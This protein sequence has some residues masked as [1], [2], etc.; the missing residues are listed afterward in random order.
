MRIDC[1]RSRSI[2]VCEQG[3]LGSIWIYSKLLA[4]SRLL[5]F[6]PNRP[7][8]KASQSRESAQPRSTL[9]NF[10]IGFARDQPGSLPLAR[11]LT[12][13]HASDLRRMPPPRKHNNRVKRSSTSSELTYLTPIS[14]NTSSQRPSYL[15]SPSTSYRQSAASM[16]RTPIPTWEETYR[17]QGLQFDRNLDI[18]PLPSLS[19]SANHQFTLPHTPAVPY[20]PSITGPPV[21]LPPGLTKL[22]PV[23]RSSLSINPPPVRRTGGIKGPR[24]LVTTSRSRGRTLRDMS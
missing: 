2:L 4:H 16:S 11:F 22:Q 18:P 17:Q 1:I 10:L 13:V 3:L 19:V 14:Q 15:L 8:R 24:P 9:V 20:V 7:G 21:S 23:T 5:Q 12:G 6:E